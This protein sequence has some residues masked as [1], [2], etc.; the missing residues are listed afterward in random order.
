MVAVRFGGTR[1]LDNAAL[2]DPPRPTGG[3]DA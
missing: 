2:A 1:L 3:P